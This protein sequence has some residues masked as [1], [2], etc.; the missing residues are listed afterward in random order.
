MV[1]ELHLFVRMGVSGGGGGVGSCG[2]V[3]PAK[4]RLRLG[5]VAGYESREWARNS[6][7]VVAAIDQQHVELGAQIGIHCGWCVGSCR[8]RYLEF[9]GWWSQGVL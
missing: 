3:P 8:P 1:S 4:E 2:M 6:L 7:L 5:G 9:S